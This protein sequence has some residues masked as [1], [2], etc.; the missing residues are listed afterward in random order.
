MAQLRYSA[1]IGLARSLDVLDAVAVEGDRSSQDDK[2][3]DHIREK[4]THA[5]INVSQLKFLECRSSPLSKRTLTRRVLLFNL[6]TR[7]PEKQ[8]RADRG[9]EDGHQRRPFI[10]GVWHR[11]Y[12][13]RTSHSAPV[14]SHHKRGYRVG[15][16]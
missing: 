8:I 15:E 6:F 4:R 3:H 2:K 16:G 10:S 7:L 11:R 9:P 14:L 5:D 13:G 1:L 12:K